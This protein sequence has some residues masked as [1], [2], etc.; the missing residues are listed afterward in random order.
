VRISIQWLSEWLGSAPEPR[1]LASRLT[2]AGLEVEAVEG[3]KR[4]PARKRLRGLL[5]KLR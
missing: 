2:M 4:D 1:E 5:K 3:V